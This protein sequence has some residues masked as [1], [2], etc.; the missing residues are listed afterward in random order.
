M[1]RTEIP[2]RQI[3]DKSVSLADD[4]VDVL[5]VANGGSGASTLAS[6]SVLLGAGTN[7]VDVVYPG[8]SGNILTSN[9]SAWISAAPATG[10]GTGDVTSTASSSVDGEIVLYSGTTGKQV[11]RA[12]GSGVMTL[13]SGVLSAV[14]SIPQ[15]SVTD[16]GSALDGK[17]AAV[18][19]HPQSDITNLTTDLAGKEPTITAGTTAQYWRGDKSW[20]TLDVA[21]VS[22]AEA[23]TNKGVANGYASLDTNAKVPVSQ[24]PNSIMTYEGLHDVSTNTPALTDAGG[25]AGRVYRISVG[26]TRN[27]GSGN[28]T[29]NV[30]DYLIHNGSV[31]QFADTTDAVSSVAGRTGDI[32]LTTTDVSGSVSLTGSET[33]TNKTLT[34]PTINGYTEGTLSLGTVGA[35]ATLSIADDSVIFATLTASTATTFTMPSVG[36]GKSFTLMLRQ[37][38]STGNGT[39]TFTGV[40][41]PTTGTPT[42]TATAGRMDIFSFFSDGTN[43]YGS[44]TQGYTP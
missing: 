28:I 17:A 9:G 37:A 12:T 10:A 36:A 21:A 11:K 42:V 34:N 35:S 25:D 18:H 44:V 13:S 22:G 7:P 3:K 16:L 43:W 40:K 2:G 24:L 14:N 33:L 1:A 4:V 31:W 29:L 41:W 6:G 5:P 15:S 38:A 26:G 8:A 27:Y 19:T 32:T 39:A 23:T 20:Q 30:G